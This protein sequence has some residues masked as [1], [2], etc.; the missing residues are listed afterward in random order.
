M[1]IKK[2]PPEAYRIGDIP[3]LNCDIDLSLRPFIPRPETE[4]WVSEAIK[5]LPPHLFRGEGRG[6]VEILDA[7]A[8]SGCIGIA[9]LKNLPNAHT[10]FIEKE[11]RLG[12]QIE[13]NLKKNNISKSRVK[14]II[15]DVLEKISQNKRKKYDYIFA[16]PPY[17]DFSKKHTVQRSVLDYEPHTA[18]FAKDHGLYY[19]KQLIEL[20][21]K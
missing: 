21:P 15:G 19:I 12:K 17:I 16:N 3:F 7:F 11:T 20:A 9:L 18:L 5:T 10:D 14:I 6:G 4:Y 2:Q 13:T 8:G 1:A